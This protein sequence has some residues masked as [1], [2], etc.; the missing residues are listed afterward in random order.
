MART[1]PIATGNTAEIHRVG[2][3]VVKV[4]T[5][6][7]RTTVELEASKQRAA[8]ALGLPV[9]A[10]IQVTEVDGKP[11]LVMEYVPGTTMIE[12]IGDDWD[13][14]PGYLVRSVEI[15]QATHAVRA[16]GL[17]SMKTKLEHQ[18]HRVV[19]VPEARK[20]VLIAKLDH[21]GT[22]TAVCHG[23]FHLQ[24]LIVN[25]DLVTI[26]DWMDATAGNPA[27]DVCRSYVLYGSVSDV[28]AEMYL[29]EYCSQSGLSAE[30]VLRWEPV[31]AAARLSETLPAYELDR[32]L[33]IIVS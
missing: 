19:L 30:E 11:A 29:Q 13:L 26:I 10:V 27:L 15:Q 12:K 16:V 23:D 28:A 32:L 31:I 21:L 33:S 2:D 25:G 1:D 8:H 17:P 18:I 9:P 14:L 5:H 3:T 6:A 22:E 24:N 20:S 4:Y 7:D